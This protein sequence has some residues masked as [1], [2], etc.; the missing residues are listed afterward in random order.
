[1]KVDSNDTDKGT[2]NKSKIEHSKTMKAD[3]ANK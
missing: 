1:M 3:F 2:M